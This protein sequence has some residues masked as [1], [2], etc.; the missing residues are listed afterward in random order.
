MDLA[1]LDYTQQGNEV[2]RF[3]LVDAAGFFLNCAAMTQNA[4]NVTL[5]ENRE[6]V[7]YFGTGRGPIGSSSGM[8]YLMKDAAI[9]PIGHKL[10]A[11]KPSHEIHIKDKDAT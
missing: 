5:Q 11:G 4:K 1:D 2:R 7:L 9:V 10:L 8:L 3:K 6:V